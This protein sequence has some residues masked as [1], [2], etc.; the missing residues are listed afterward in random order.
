MMAQDLDAGMVRRLRLTLPQLLS[1]KKKDKDKNHVRLKIFKID[2]RTADT[3]A[4]TK[5]YG[6]T[7]GK[8]N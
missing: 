7:Y 4:L 2:K 8:K 5:I 3:N 1:L 6:N